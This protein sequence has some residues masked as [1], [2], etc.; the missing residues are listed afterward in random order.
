LSAARKRERAAP[1]CQDRHH[2][3]GIRPEAFDLKR[4]S[5]R[6]QAM[7][8][9]DHK[10]TAEAKPDA[11]QIWVIAPGGGHIIVNILT[12]PHWV[13]ATAE[14]LHPK[15]EEGGNKVNSTRLTP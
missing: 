13:D 2:V 14:R 10:E 11:R 8:G 6:T 12:R 15:P 3:E 4:E 9:I 7:Y 1:Q 5:D